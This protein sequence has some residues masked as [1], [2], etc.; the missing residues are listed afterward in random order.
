MENYAEN[1]QKDELEIRYGVNK[2]DFHLLYN[3]AISMFSF[4]DFLANSCGEKLSEILEYFD[5][6]L[7]DYQSLEI[8]TNFLSDEKGNPLILREKLEQKPDNLTARAWKL[9]NN[10]PNLVAFEYSRWPAFAVLLKLD[11]VLCDSIFEF[12]NIVK[13]DIEF[14]I[15]DIIEKIDAIKESSEINIVESVK[16]LPHWVGDEIA[17]LCGVNYNFVKLQTDKFQK[18]INNMKLKTYPQAH[19][20]YGRSFSQLNAYKFFLNEGF[21]DLQKSFKTVKTFT[22]E[23]KNT[24][25]PIIEEHQK[26]G[27]LEIITGDERTIQEVT[28]VRVEEEKLKWI[29]RNSKSSIENIYE[30]LD[31]LEIQAGLR[32]VSRS[33][34][35]RNL[36]KVGRRGMADLA[37]A[38]GLVSEK[39]G[40]ISHR[41]TT[42]LKIQDEKKAKHWAQSAVVR[43]VESGEEISLYEITKKKKNARLSSIYAITSAYV[44]EA[45]NAGLSAFFGTITLPPEFHPAPKSHG[46]RKNKNWQFKKNNCNETKNYLS[47]LISLFRANLKKVKEFRGMFG[48]K[49]IEFHEDG[50]PHTHFLFFL[51]PQIHDRKNLTMI[52][53]YDVVSKILNRL[54]GGSEDTV[55]KNG[56]D[57]I[58]H[59]YDLKLIE[60]NEDDDET[61]SPASYIMTYIKKSLEVTDADEM[62]YDDEA[63]RHKSQLSAFGLRG[64][65]FWGGRSVKSICDRLYNMHP[66]N[67]SKLPI[68]WLNIYENLQLSKD[69]WK[70]GTD[71]K[72]DIEAKNYKNISK[73]YYRKALTLLNAFPHSRQ[74]YKI[75]T[76]YDNSVNKFLEKSEKLIGWSIV[77]EHEEK[78]FLPHRDVEVVVDAKEIEP[79]Y[80]IIKI[81]KYQ[82]NMPLS[83]ANKV[84]SSSDDN[85]EKFIRVKINKPEIDRT[86]IRKNRMRKEI[87]ER[88]FNVI[89]EFNFIDSLKIQDIYTNKLDD[90]YKHCI[91]DINYVVENTTYNNL[92]SLISNY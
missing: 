3:D 57:A 23:T 27:T 88:L 47:D 32:A 63:V 17:N 34:I 43:I 22:D 70:K 46:S 11:T 86:G 53:S 85:E 49:V 78:H 19:K 38:L 87:T 48:F 67:G 4:I 21:R 62:T 89:D 26:L 18:L 16:L 64:Y 80:K 8:I 76:E 24:I 2:E 31:H 28:D 5:I 51:P 14:E 79:E 83:K 91:T 68:L 71:E 52:N 39:R 45:E 44:A 54:T 92:V 1:Y 75:V 12:G 60:K 69:F 84:D 61:A 36:R 20:K 72:N 7:Y 37:S 35:S 81:E 41:N 40:S 50:C 82:Y 58:N 59:R 10:F 25:L 6:S 77:D 66:K 55:N 90:I 56:E 13:Q 30:K 15:N 74:D 33:N 42:R 29:E 9:K 65:S 73:E